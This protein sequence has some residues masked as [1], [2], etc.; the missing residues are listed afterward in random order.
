MA[1]QLPHTLQLSKGMVLH[2]GKGQVRRFPTRVADVTKLGLSLEGD[3]ME[4]PRLV[5]FAMEY[6]RSSRDR[7]LR[8]D[9]ERELQVFAA[10]LV[11]CRKEVSLDQLKHYMQT[12]TRLDLEQSTAVIISAFM[13]EGRVHDAVRL[14]GEVGGILTT[15]QMWINPRLP[16]H[17]PQDPFDSLG[18]L[19]KQLQLSAAKM[20]IVVPLATTL[21]D[22]VR[23]LMR[24]RRCK[25]EDRCLTI[26][27]WMFGEAGIDPPSHF[28]SHFTFSQ[29]G[30]HPVAPR[31]TDSIVLTR[32]H[33][34]AVQRRVFHIFKFWK[35]THDFRRRV[36]KLADEV[37]FGQ[38]WMDPRVF[39]VEDV[40]LLSHY[41]FASQRKLQRKVVSTL[42]G[43]S[44]L[45]KGEG[46]KLYQNNLA[47]KSTFENVLVDIAESSHD[48]VIVATGSDNTLPLID[49]TCCMMKE[50]VDLYGD[51]DK[52]NLVFKKGQ[53]GGSGQGPVDEYN[54]LCDVLSSLRHQGEEEGQTKLPG[55][56]KKFL[57]K[58]IMQW[59]ESWEDDAFAGDEKAA[60]EDWLDQR[61]LND[62]STWEVVIREK[63]L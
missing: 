4:T 2:G 45:A 1:V 56:N 57:A 25:P 39:A 53:I 43:R 23:L 28:Q 31:D 22:L 47:L 59:N 29:K 41:F 50:Y 12:R 44:F 49:Q 6:L 16:L 37:I 15:S 61:G 60:W 46:R 14:I 24:V 55:F 11:A 62:D 33:F 20:N 13:T 19:A 32:R 52:K 10:N 36:K 5:S 63:E 26:P 48:G 34:L 27:Q 7:M 17:A 30:K 9:C 35:P 18:N 21:P 51:G 8:T 38:S 42:D 40:A 3:K 54:L 58:D